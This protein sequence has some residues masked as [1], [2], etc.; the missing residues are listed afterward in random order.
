MNELTTGRTIFDAVDEYDEKSAAIEQTVREFQHAVDKVKMQAAIGGTFGGSIFDREPYL[1]ARTIK[2]TLLKSAWKHV[3][4]RLSIAQVSSAADR[5]AFERAVEDPPEFT[6]DNIKATFGQYVANP[7]EH[8][9]RGLAEVFCQLDDAYKSHSKVMIGVKGLP[10]R[11]ILTNC[12]GYGSWGYERLRDTVNA[13]RAVEG[14]PLLEGHELDTFLRRA[15]LNNPLPGWSPDTRYRYSNTVAHADAIWRI[16]GNSLPAVGVAPNA[17]ESGWTEC[18]NP[19]PDLSLRR[20]QNGNAHLIFG[21]HTLRTINLALAEYYGDVLPDAEDDNATPQASREVAKDLQYYPTPV[22]VVERVLSDIYFPDDCKVLEP[23]CGCGRFLDMLPN[24][25]QSLGIEVDA[26]RAQE[27]RN[28]G[29]AVQRANFLEIPSPRHE[30]E[31]YNHVVMNP[32]FYGRHYL[33]HV[34]H[35]MA[36]VLPGGSLTAV[37]PSSA[38]YDHKEL[39]KGG[40]WRDLPVGSF[41]ESGTRVPTGVFTWRAPR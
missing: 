34:R 3:Y 7:R 23:S 31:R 15:D 36:F 25:V 26:T 18:H 6:L 20:F 12:A 14:R 22:A 32:P 24:H 33:K 1:H 13:L 2:Q 8:I 16:G 35:A 38:W 5:S 41:A 11:V 19:E 37:L 10:K 21:P 27:A 29:H 17:D 40:Q 4:D 9:L 30:L 39:P 28:K